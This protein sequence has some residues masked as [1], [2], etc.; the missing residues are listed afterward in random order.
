MSIQKKPTQ[1]QHFNILKLKGSVHQKM[2]I[3]SLFTDPFVVLIPYTLCI[4]DQKK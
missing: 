4:S 3:K 1:S 2:K